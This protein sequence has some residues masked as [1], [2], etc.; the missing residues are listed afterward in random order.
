M[1]E[2]EKTFS[3]EMFDEGLDNEETPEGDTSKPED[4]PE[5]SPDADTEPETAPEGADTEPETAD[6]D[7]ETQERLQRLQQIEEAFGQVNPHGYYKDPI[8][9]FNRLSEKERYITQL[10]Q[11]QAEILRSMQQPKTEPK[12]PVTFDPDMWAENPQR[13]FETMI[14]QAGYITKDEA[15]EIARTSA[16]EQA[17]E[18]ESRQ[19]LSSKG[20]RQGDTMWA[21]MDAKLYENPDL[22]RLPKST[23]LRVLYDMV[24]PVETGKPKVETQ[25]APGKNKKDRADTGG[26]NP[27]GGELKSPQPKGGL[28]PEQAAKMSEEE[29]AAFYGFSD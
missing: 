13:A 15:T 11:Q 21:K 18:L 20:I 29:L 5:P 9:A 8:D 17:D 2:D 25:P 10:Q 1:P 23:M 6:E 14:K 12:Q 27:R 19:F 22:Q 4:K 28:T 3:D 26:G 24:G 16:S 7:V